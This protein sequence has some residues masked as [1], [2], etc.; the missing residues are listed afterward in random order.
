MKNIVNC[1]QMKAMDAFTIQEMGL[2]SCVLMERAALSVVEVLEQKIAPSDKIVVV[3]GSGNN[4]G[5]GIAI[6]RILH[7]HGFIADV[8]LAGSIEKMTPETTLQ[9]KIA[10]NYGISFV[11]ILQWSEY[12]VIVDAIFGVGLTREIEGS[13]REL[14][15]EMNQAKACKVAV[16]LPSGIDGDDGKILGAAF[17]ADITVTF[18]YRKRGLCFYPGRMYAGKIITADIGIYTKQDV[19]QNM[20]LGDLTE[21]KES[22]FYANGDVQC[23][24]KTDLQKL[25]VRVPFGNKGTFG[26]VL[27]VAGSKGMC[28]ASY[29]AASAALA[30]GC[31]MVKIVTAE[32]NRIP[33]QT[34]LPEAMISCDVSEEENKKNLNW[35]DVLV[36][37]PGVG[38]SKVA[39]ERVEWFL[40]H[41]KE[42]EKAVILDADGLNLLAANP[43]WQEILPANLILTPHVGEMSRLCGKAIAEIQKSLIETALACAKKYHAVCVLKDACTVIADTKGSVFL[44]LSGNA[45][46]ATAGS[47]DVLAGLLGALLCMEWTEETVFAAALGVWIHGMGGDLAAA[48]VGMHSLKARDIIENINGVLQGKEGKE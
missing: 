34:M 10:E 12:T 22:P 7:L 17:R 24:E 33:L 4:G 48:K 8:F 21:S 43:D 40:K 5:D 13:F 47:G 35:C 3:C 39:A 25:P 20:Q 36:I 31:G 32:E 19:R 9:Y 44:N 15:L 41:T 2:P 30:G 45:G 14:I 29:F 11:N 37:G 42:A 23:I 16:D 18:A 1:A 28:G 38:T 46:M 26:K 6:A 27:V